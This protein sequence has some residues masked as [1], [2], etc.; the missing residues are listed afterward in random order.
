MKKLLLIILLGTIMSLLVSCNA[1]VAP[2]IREMPA[3]PFWQDNQIQAY[4]P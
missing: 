2:D 1:P 4:I 3:K